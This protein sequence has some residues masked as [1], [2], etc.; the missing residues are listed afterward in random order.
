MT[1][2]AMPATVRG[3]TG[4][5]RSRET[6]RKIS[7]EARRH[8]SAPRPVHVYVNPG[9]DTLDRRVLWRELLRAARVARDVDVVSDHS[10][11]QAVARAFAYAIQYS[12]RTLRMRAL[13]LLVG[14]EAKGKLRVDA[15]E[16]SRAWDEMDA[17]H[18]E[19]TSPT[20]RPRAPYQEEN[21]R[22]RLPVERARAVPIAEVFQ[23]VGHRLRS[24]GHSL[25]GRCPLPDHDD[26]TPSL[27]V[28]PKRGLWYCH[29]CHRGG[30]G[31]RLIQLMHRVPFAAAVQE[32][33][34]AC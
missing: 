33:V 26:S 13:A 11:P 3:S 9:A 15:R 17:L 4:T 5:Y 31:I 32:L 22:E 2:T 28:D 10:A 14:L 20:P 16:C 29:G 23:H 18:R 30:D 7:G 24:T 25:I 21:G 34:A 8:P 12:D 1:A 19:I 6:A 27:S